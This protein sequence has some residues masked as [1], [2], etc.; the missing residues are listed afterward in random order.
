MSPLLEFL[1]GILLTFTHLLG[2]LKDLKASINT[3]H[4]LLDPGKVTHRPQSELLE[5]K[6]VSQQHHCEDPLLPS[7]CLTGIDNTES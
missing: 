3:D 4:P 1:G 5:K 2:D 6:H 7:L